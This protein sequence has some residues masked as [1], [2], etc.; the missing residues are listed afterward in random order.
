MFRIEILESQL[1]WEFCRWLWI[2]QTR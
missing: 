1:S 2:W